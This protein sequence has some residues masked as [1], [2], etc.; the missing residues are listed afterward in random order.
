MGI[1]GGAI[2]SEAS[3]CLSE[4]SRCAPARVSPFNCCEQIWLLNSA[5]N[6]LHHC[7]FHISM[8]LSQWVQ[9]IGGALL[10]DPST[11]GISREHTGHATSFPAS[12]PIPTD[13]NWANPSELWSSHRVFTYFL[14]SAITSGSIPLLIFN[15]QQTRI[16]NFLHNNSV[17]IA[18]QW[19]T[20]S[21]CMQ[22]LFYSLRYHFHSL[23]LPF[24]PLHI[25]SVQ[26]SRT[27]PH[28]LSQHL[29]AA[30]WRRQCVLL[31]PT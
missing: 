5:V 20:L 30:E 18:L 15:W 31:V 29:S 7:F 27:A 6:I 9:L 13:D 2:I 11:M 24:H 16:P 4:A 19:G 12:V 26:A 25:R 14:P 17:P 1:A 28:P 22:H 10:S 21:P 3:I 8:H 23:L